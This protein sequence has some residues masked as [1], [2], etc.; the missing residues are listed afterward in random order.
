MCL[1]IDEVEP[2]HGKAEKYGFVQ[3]LHAFI[4]NKPVHTATTGDIGRGSR[5]TI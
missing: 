5:S 4:V 2:V 1:H 3:Q